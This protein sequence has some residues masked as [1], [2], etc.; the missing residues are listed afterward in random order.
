MSVWSPISLIGE[1]GLAIA[2]SSSLA[3][4]WIH[5]ARL[6]PFTSYRSIP[7]CQRHSKGVALVPGNRIKRRDS[8]GTTPVGRGELAK[9]NAE[10]VAKIVRILR[11]LSL[12]PATPDQARAM[13]GL[14]GADKV[15]F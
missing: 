3:S 15:G 14:K 11:E 1:T 8:C 10:M 13:L 6:S 2:L 7:V 5:Q 12:E 9:S 4:M